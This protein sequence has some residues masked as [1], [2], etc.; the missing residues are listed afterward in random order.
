LNF[1]IDENYFPYTKES[2]AANRKIFY[3]VLM[4]SVE[5]IVKIKSEIETAF[6]FAYRWSA[7]KSE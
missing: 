7:L 1:L 5:E 6:A 3:Y 4:V 2:T